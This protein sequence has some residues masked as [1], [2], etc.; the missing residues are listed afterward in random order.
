MSTAVLARPPR[1]P[2]VRPRALVRAGA[3]PATTLSGAFATPPD[4]NGILPTSATEGLVRSQ[5]A[6]VVRR[7]PEIARARLVVDSPDGN[8]R[9]TLHVEMARV[10]ATI[11]PSDGAATAEAIQTAI[12]DITKLRGEVAFRR[13]GELPND[14]KVIDDTRK[15][16]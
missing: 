2:P 9:M 1:E 7:F 12:R 6:A 15:F 10:G 8:D 4:P 5:V 11:G 14:G 3:E 16:D 13:E